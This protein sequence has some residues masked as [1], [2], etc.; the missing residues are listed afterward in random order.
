MNK[1][2]IIQGIIISNKKVHVGLYVKLVGLHVAVTVLLII[3][4]SLSPLQKMN[5]LTPIKY[6]YMLC[7]HVLNKEIY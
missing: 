2:I 7:K 1:L 6:L 3:A 5:T 4:C